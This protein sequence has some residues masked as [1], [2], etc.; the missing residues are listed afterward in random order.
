MQN[1]SCIYGTGVGYAIYMFARPAAHSAGCSD[2]RCCNAVK[3][4][5]SHIKAIYLDLI[6]GV[7]GGIGNW[8]SYGSWM[9]H[10]FPLD[11]LKEDDS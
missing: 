10:F 11:P 2:L 1:V 6:L 8:G 9:G 7:M 4:H 3:A 5:K